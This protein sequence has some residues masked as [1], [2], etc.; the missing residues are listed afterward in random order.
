M[1]LSWLGGQFP[2]MLTYLTFFCLTN[3][4]EITNLF[5]DFM[6]SMCG[7]NPC[8]DLYSSHFGTISE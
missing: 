4:A 6:V 7:T 2:L 3:F 5:Y 1:L 8:V